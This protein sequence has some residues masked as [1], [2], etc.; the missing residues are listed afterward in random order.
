MADEWKGGTEGDGFLSPACDEAA[1]GV[2][3]GAAEV[4]VLCEGLPEGLFAGGRRRG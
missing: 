4:M 2:V 1:G 3:E